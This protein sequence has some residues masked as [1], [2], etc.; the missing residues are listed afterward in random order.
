VIVGVDPEALTA[1]AGAAADAAATLDGFADLAVLGGADDAGT[2]EVADA[3]GDVAADWPVRRARLAEDLRML[4]AFA[5]AATEAM[6]A[7]DGQLVT[8]DIAR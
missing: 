4:G 5:A 6:T 2:G 1:A 3:Y 7:L 8:V